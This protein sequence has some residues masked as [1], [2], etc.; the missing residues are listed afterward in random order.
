VSQKTPDQV[1][2]EI[3]KVFKKIT[4]SRTTLQNTADLTENKFTSFS[5]EVEDQSYS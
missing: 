3:I 4:T 5:H 1:V 2:A